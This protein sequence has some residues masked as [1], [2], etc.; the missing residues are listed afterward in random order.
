MYNRHTEFMV[1][2]TM[3]NEDSV[4][5]SRSLHHIFENVRDI[6]RLKTSEFWNKGGPAWQKI[7]V[8]IIVDG[9]EAFDLNILDVL[10]TLGVYQDGLMK[11]DFRGK[12]VQAHIVS[13]FFPHFP[14]TLT[15]SSVPKLNDNRTLPEHRSLLPS[16]YSSDYT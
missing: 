4:L 15:A 13:M 7:V 6:A 8:C 9:L 16:K 11:R 1:C 2:I 3:H 5:M 12:D 14:C 10:A